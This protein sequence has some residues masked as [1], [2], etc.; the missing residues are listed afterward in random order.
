VDADV[1]IYSRSMLVVPYWSQGHSFSAQSLM[2][3]YNLHTNILQ[4]EL[5]GGK[6]SN[7]QVRMRVNR[8]RCEPA[9]GRTGKGVKEC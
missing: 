6:L 7:V 8:P 9:T 4:E 1:V 2:F 3:V 5:K